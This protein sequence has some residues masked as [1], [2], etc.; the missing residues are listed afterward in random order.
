MYNPV[1]V[2]IEMDEWVISDTSV[3]VM[4]PRDNHNN[5]DYGPQGFDPSQI[6]VL[7]GL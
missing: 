6:R 4:C 2:N 5:L 3:L 1:G 7:I